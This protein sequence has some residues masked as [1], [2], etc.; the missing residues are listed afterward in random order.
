MRKDFANLEYGRD[1]EFRSFQEEEFVD[2]DEDED[3]D[4]D[5]EVADQ[6]SNL[7]TKDHIRQQSLTKSITTVI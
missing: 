5:G 4:D 6:G 3:G 7:A 2:A 1:Y